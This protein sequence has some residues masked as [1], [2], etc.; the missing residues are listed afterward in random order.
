MNTQHT[1]GDLKKSSMGA[2]QNTV[3]HQCKEDEDR[4]A[5]T[6][7]AWPLTEKSELQGQLDITKGF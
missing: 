7:G 5:Q 4:R 3:D 1:A 6:H 2:K